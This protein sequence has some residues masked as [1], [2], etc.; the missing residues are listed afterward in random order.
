[1]TYR[2]LDRRVSRLEGP[3]VSP[4]DEAALD[5]EIERLLAD[6]ERR[7]GPDAVARFFAEFE[8]S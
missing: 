8:L 4:E 3:R 2:D 7:E 1:M 6:L 5:A